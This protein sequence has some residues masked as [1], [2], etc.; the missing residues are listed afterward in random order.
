MSVFLYYP[1]TNS[2]L[3]LRCA[4]KGE[5]LPVAV[6]IRLALQ[7]LFGPPVKM[8]RDVVIEHLNLRD[9]LNQI[10]LFLPHL[11]VQQKA[12]KKSNLGIDSE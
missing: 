2:F 3:T 8:G 7:L 1:V 11:C 12:C 6:R 9:S 5:Y 4:L 10:G